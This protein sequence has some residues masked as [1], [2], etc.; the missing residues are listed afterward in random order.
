MR[1]RIYETSTDEVI[2][3]M[4]ITP[5]L[6]SQHDIDPNDESFTHEFETEI[7]SDIFE[8]NNLHYGILFDFCIEMDDTYYELK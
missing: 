3:E 8:E 2:Y 1:L 5:K 7:L 4:D 6:L